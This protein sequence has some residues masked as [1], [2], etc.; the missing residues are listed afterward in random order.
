MGNRRCECRA[1]RRCPSHAI[2]SPGKKAR[3]CTGR[4]AEEPSHIHDFRIGLSTAGTHAYRTGVVLSHALPLVARVGRSR[5]SHSDDSVGALGHCVERA[6]AG[7]CP[8]HTLHTLRSNLPSK[9]TVL[10]ST[11]SRHTPRSQLT[12]HVPRSH[13][14]EFSKTGIGRGPDRWIYLQSEERLQA[15]TE[16]NEP[17]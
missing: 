11:L 3:I 17:L 8:N 7:T 13:G 1:R 2:Q 16:K 15:C 10:P 5:L 4:L 6:S 12:A 14:N 9:L